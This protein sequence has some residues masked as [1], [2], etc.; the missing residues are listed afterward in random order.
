MICGEWHIN[1]GMSDG[2][3]LL[4]SAPALAPREGKELYLNW[5]K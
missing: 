1:V 2:T 5:L 3:I 4:F